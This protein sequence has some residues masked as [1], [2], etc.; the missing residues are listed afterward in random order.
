[1]EIDPEEKTK[2]SP[3]RRRKLFLPAKQGLVSDVVLPSS[4]RPCPHLFTPILVDNIIARDQLLRE[5]DRRVITATDTETTG[6]KIWADK[7]IGIC[8][9]FPPFDVGYYVPMYNS[10]EGTVWWE[11]PKDFEFWQK[12][13][14]DYFSSGVETIFHNALFDVPMLWMN[15]SIFVKNITHDTLLKCHVIDSESELGLK[16]NSVK[17]ISPLADWYETELHRYNSAVGGTIKNPKYWLIPVKKVCEYGSGDSVFTGRLHMILDKLFIPELRHVYENI[18]MQLTRNLMEM[19]VNGV[20]FDVPYMQR[21]QQWYTAKLEHLV[22]V[23]REKIGRPDFNPGSNDQLMDVLYKQLG[24]PPGRKGKKGYSTDKNELKRLKGQHPVIE[25]LEEYR[26]TDKLKGT[27]FD[28]LLADLS[29]NGLFHPD[30]KPWGTRT[31]RLSM[32][33]LHQIPRGPLIRKAVIA[34]EGYVFVGGDHS[35]LEARVL[36]HFSQD[37]EL[38]R[39]YKQGRD[40]HSETAKMMFNL[41]CQATEVAKLYPDMRQK[42]KSIN[43]ALLYLETP[44]GLQMQLGCTYAEALDYYKRF[45]NIYAG[46]LPW[47]EKEIK[48]GRNHGFVKMISSR[49]R[50]LPELV[51]H[52]V[53]KPRY[54]GHHNV[55]VCYGKPRYKGGIAM[56]VHFDLSLDL[57]NWTREKAED[58]RPLLKS[59][60]KGECSVCPNLW[61]CYYALDY[62]R[63]KK[64]IEHNERTALNTK[65]QGSAAD[66]TN[67]GINRTGEMCS[68]NSIDGWLALYVHDEVAYCVSTNMNIDAFAKDFRKAMESVSE[69]MSVP[70][71]FEPKVGKSWNDI[72]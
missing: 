42:G 62:N 44:R 65:I 32:A 46:V 47:A 53:E 23:I 68:R 9:S 71:V 11:N 38:V 64:E 51:C 15:L 10:P 57:V 28:G 70:L 48:V 37:K 41:N 5:L 30:I 12:M 6:L 60:G 59:A 35:Q 4:P 29:P 54:M 19:R 13:F 61:G 18:S 7:I 27:Y 31:G 8:L 58:M 17:R 24:L 45:F 33:R 21:G 39:I 56:S 63:A 2:K 72:K 36:A 66:L 67:L 20:A 69:Y 22:E 26:S 52:P 34:P 16:E 55:P 25:M 43:F 50:Y 3:T 14:Q 49:R 1:M 40:I